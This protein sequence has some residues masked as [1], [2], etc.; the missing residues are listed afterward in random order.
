MY[1]RR[2]TCA[3]ACA[4]QSTTSNQV[5]SKQE[6]RTHHKYIHTPQLKPHRSQHNNTKHSSRCL[7]LT[8]HTDAA[9]EVAINRVENGLMFFQFSEVKV[10]AAQRSRLGTRQMH[11]RFARSTRRKLLRHT[12]HHICLRRGRG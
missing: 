11:E 1:G 5:H 10:R 6:K 4:R 12:G 9:T 3:C 8:F 2:I 7:P